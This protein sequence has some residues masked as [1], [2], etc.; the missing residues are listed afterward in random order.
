MKQSWERSLT[1]QLSFICLCFSSSKIYSKISEMS[2]DV[3][4]WT[5]PHCRTHYDCDLNA[6]ISIK[7][8]A[9]RI[10]KAEGD[11]RTSTL[12]QATQSV[13]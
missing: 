3:R 5:C 4:E 6:A 10:L 8:E 9:I 12:K 2:L 11:A 7:A 13:P 1:P